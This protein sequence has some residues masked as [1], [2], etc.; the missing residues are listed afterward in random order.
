M[1]IEALK[2]NTKQVKEILREMYVF[3]N[4][5][6]IIKNLETSS[7]IAIN[8]KEKMLLSSSIIALKN[9]LIILT[10]T[11]PELVGGPG[12]YQKTEIADSIINDLLILRD[13]K[14]PDLL[15]KNASFTPDVRKTNSSKIFSRQTKHSLNS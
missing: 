6:D 15:K 14:I 5:L 12:F 13:R 8:A 11:I 9:Q 2:N 10:N 1:N 3:T 4:Q 7:E